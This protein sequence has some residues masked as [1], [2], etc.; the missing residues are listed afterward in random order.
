MCLYVLIKTEI[1]F[2]LFANILSPVHEIKFTNLNVFN[3][4]GIVVNAILLLK[5]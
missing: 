1:V 4:Y 2:T 5:N 3:N